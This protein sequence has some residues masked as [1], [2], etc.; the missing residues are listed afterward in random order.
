MGGLSLD[1]KRGLLFFTTGNPAPW[2][3][4]VF[5]PGD[6]LYAN[7]LVAFDLNQ[8]KLNGTF[9]KFHMIFGTTI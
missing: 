4:G 3:V 7:S 5:R 1:E 9:K 8:K 6:N 2:L